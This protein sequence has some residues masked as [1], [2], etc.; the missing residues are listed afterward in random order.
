MKGRLLSLIFLMNVCP[1]ILFAQFNYVS[2]S[3]IY[4][5]AFE[6]ARNKSLRIQKTI[7]IG[8]EYL[9]SQYDIRNGHQYFLTDQEIKGEIVYN[10]VLYRNVDLQYD[11]VQD[12]V[13]TKH[14][15]GKKI[16]LIKDK[17]SEFTLA[18]HVFR[19][20]DQ[21]KAVDRVKPGFYDIL[22]DE[23]NIKLLAKREKRIRGQTGNFYYKKE[24][25][26]VESSVKYFFVEDGN[27]Q[28]VKNY[29]SIIKLA[30]DKRRES[31]L[32]LAS[33]EKSQEARMIDIVKQYASLK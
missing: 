12:E 20:L 5:T 7:N 16:I 10:N 23:T 27:F 24:K 33:K 3:G 11:L 26:L 22:V 1:T 21:F 30:A 25:S 2:D 17:I 28:S 15:S 13:V 32:K 18:G 29:K 4:R 6:N 8:S 31:V 9:E 19:R 14:F